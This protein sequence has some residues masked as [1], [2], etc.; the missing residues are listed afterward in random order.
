MAV[1]RLFTGPTDPPTA[2]RLPVGLPPSKLELDLQQ[3]WREPLTQPRVLR[4]T[5]GSVVF[6]IVAVIL[7][8][9]VPETPFEFHARPVQL[10]IVRP[11]HL[12]LPK[13]FEL[14]QKDPNNGPVTHQLDVR[15]MLSAPAPQAPKFR[16]PSPPPGPVAQRP[17]PVKVAAVD[18]P[19]IEA[20]KI[21]TPK[22]EAP[23]QEAPKIE[24]P[25]TTP[26]VVAAAPK[27]AA[28]PTP[29]KPKLT[30][31][32]VGA[33]IRTS[34]NPN[35]SVPLP[36]DLAPDPIH[37]QTAPGGGGTIV[38]D[39][40]DSSS[41]NP[42]AM[43]SAS[44]GE[45]KSNLQLLSD[46]KGVDF[47]PYMIQVLTAVRRNWLAILPQSARLGQRGRVIV[48]FAIDRSGGVP[49]VVIAEGAGT[50]AFDRAAV[51]AISASVPLPPLPKDFTGDRISLQFA[52]SY[53]MPAR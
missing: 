48:Q 1:L 47:K 27:A 23:K 9:T 34:S 36:R 52:F 46:P 25:V 42:N 16:P 43:R 53:N 7:W 3:P 45:V 51:A 14:T 15:S 29:E 17:Q 28:P 33:G 20:P 49:K 13:N 21:E 30:F 18:P 24:V 19:K 2:V 37:A 32:D 31:E 44:P 40:G 41:V 26:P 35:R 39:L 4:A 22:P 11:V 5:I 50:D 12:Y 6:H 8:I 38:G 10:E